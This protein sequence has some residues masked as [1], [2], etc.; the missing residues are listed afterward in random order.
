[1]ASREGDANDLKGQ[2]GVVVGHGAMPHPDHPEDGFD[3]LFV[4]L[5]P[6]QWVICGSTAE[7]GGYDFAEARKGLGAPMDGEVFAPLAKRG[8]PTD[9]DFAGLKEIF[10]KSWPDATM[11]WLEERD[12]KKVVVP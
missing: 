2:R 1:M 6:G 3:G 5:I 11:E 7:F 12:D 8:V 9:T 10:E 4:V